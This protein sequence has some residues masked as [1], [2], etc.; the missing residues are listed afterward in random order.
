M[1]STYSSHN[2]APRCQRCGASLALNDPR[3]TNCGY[4]NG[5][6]RP[7]NNASQQSQAP[8]VASWNQP[9]Q[10]AAYEQ[11]PSPNQPAPHQNGGLLKR[12]S[13]QTEQRNHY[14]PHASFPVAP[15]PPAAPRPVPSQTS[16]NV[17][18]PQVRQQPDMPPSVAQPL[19]MPSNENRY[20]PPS[21][22]LLNNSEYAQNASQST[23]SSPYSTGPTTPPAS[24]RASAQ[25]VPPPAYAQTSRSFSQKPG[26]QR[27]LSIGRVIGV[28]VLLL[29][30]IGGSFLAYTFLFVHKD[31]QQVTSG[32][33]LHHSST[34]LAATPQGHPLFQDEFM[35]NTNEW[36]I[37]SYPG[38]FSVALGNGALKLEN[39]NNKLL[40]E[41]VPGA[42]KYTDFQ[43]SVD[44][45]L[46]KGSQGNG[47]GVYIR[48][49]L[50]QNSSITAFYRFELYG[51][52]SFAIFKGT[53]DANGTLTTPRLADYTN[54][55]AIQKQGGLNHITIT[56]KGSSLQFIVNGQ[57]LSTVSDATYTSGSVALFV[58]NLQK[59]PPGA[60]A[61]FSHL[62]IYPAQN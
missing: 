47:Y 57:T 44:A 37:Q 25:Y 9:A 38:E 21:G 15:Q 6:P 20:A 55:S 35:N 40:W 16:F 5:G 24:F 7:G 1:S 33:V 62:A 50:S 10:P 3:C 54:S 22:Q 30:V 41:L 11:T 58:S 56:A 18:P 36:S 52:G 43:L 31:T 17:L 60:V 8:G 46:S 4:F 32:A 61:T 29:V 2:T 48:S 13:V 19:Q 49:A 28:L 42:Q 14:T 23:T 12:Y 53:T 39:D 27:Q 34:P 45:V 51:D 59:A 26:R